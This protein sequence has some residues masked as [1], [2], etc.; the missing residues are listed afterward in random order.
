MDFFVFFIIFM[1]GF[2]IGE[3]ITM[4]RLRNSLNR[5]SKELKLDFPSKDEDTQIQ[6]SL[7]MFTERVGDVLYLY[8]KETDK[9]ICQASTIEELGI[10]AKQYKNI[11]RGTIVHDD[12]VFLLL[13]GSIK[14][15]KSNEN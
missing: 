3:M 13:D 12:K 14:E 1:F 2:V 4:M 9:F 11:K 7:R 6:K 5:I 15:L 10:L 8:D